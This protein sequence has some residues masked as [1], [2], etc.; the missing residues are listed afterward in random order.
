MWAQKGLIL[1]FLFFL[2]LIVWIPPDPPSP[3][4][5]APRKKSRE[6]GILTHIKEKQPDNVKLIEVMQ[7]L[8]QSGLCV[9]LA[10]QS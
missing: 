8:T 4:P 3:Y 2:F 9:E 1:I 7:I 6:D 10:T 5:N